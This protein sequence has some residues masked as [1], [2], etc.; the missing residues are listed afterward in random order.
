MIYENKVESRSP[1][2]HVLKNG[3]IRIQ[4]QWRMP[5]GSN[6][7]PSKLPRGNEIRSII[8]YNVVP[9]TLRKLFD[10]HESERRLVS[11]RRGSLYAHSK[12]VAA[13]FFSSSTNL[14]S[15]GLSLAQSRRSL[16]RSLLYDI[17]HLPRAKQIHRLGGCTVRMTPTWTST[18]VDIWD[19]WT[20]HGRA[21]GIWNDDL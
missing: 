6:D 19:I 21:C 15:H 4:A 17:V 16:R 5:S 2:V 8:L 13:M 9:R 11:C 18:R 1:T 20:G 10:L 3:F 12:C 14:P 7:L